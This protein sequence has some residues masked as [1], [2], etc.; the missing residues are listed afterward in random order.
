MEILGPSP[1]LYPETNATN[2]HKGGNYNDNL[3]YPIF[4]SQKSQIRWG[5]DPYN[6][7]RE[8]SFQTSW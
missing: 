8:G 4:R 2:F 7:S 1:T 5:P 6:G 3:V